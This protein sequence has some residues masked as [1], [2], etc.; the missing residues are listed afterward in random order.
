M[1]FKDNKDADKPATGPLK[2]NGIP[3]MHFK[4]N[5]KADDEKK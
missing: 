5:K 1:T 4:T 3:D 2:K